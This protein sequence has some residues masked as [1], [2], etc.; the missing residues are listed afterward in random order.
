MK[1]YFRNFNI[2]KLLFSY[3]LTFTLSF[4]AN[5]EENLWIY[6]KGA[7][8]RPKGSF[9]VKLSDIIRIDKSSGK[10]IFHDIR[11]EIEYGITDKLTIGAE[12]IIFDHNYSVNDD[13]LNPMY[14]TQ[15]AD[16]KFKK[17]QYAGYE[18]ALKYNLLSPFKD[19]IGL[20]LGLSYEDRDRYRLDGAKIDQK[21]YVGT[22]FVQKNWI[23]NLLT[24]AINLKTEL[25]RRKSAADS[26]LEE[27]VAFDISAG[28][29][30]RF[31]P[32]HF[33]G[34]EVRMQ[35]D[36]L[37][38][39]ENGIKEPGLQSSNWDLDD[40][41]IGTRHQYGW[42]AGPTYHYAQKHWWATA[43]ILFQF[44]GGGSQHAY[45]KNSKNY[46]EHEKMHI[47]LSYGYEF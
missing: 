1:I 22:I 45:N 26:V 17:T 19:D 27:E 8:T 30:Y 6:T 37:S 11:P 38:P 44:H 29:S 39:S 13:N 40:I 4:F 31:I 25:E 32:K 24:L 23:D 3:L 34:F 46:D 7:D 35:S 14:E 41:S 20:S 36:Y 42:Y 16:N 9:E 28:I 47:G 12:A 15:G 43:G 10:Y 33:I 21:S 2:Y 5:A 18:V